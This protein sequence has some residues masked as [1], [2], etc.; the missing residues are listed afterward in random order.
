MLFLQLMLQNFSGGPCV[1]RRPSQ[2]GRGLKRLLNVHKACAL[3]SPLARGA[4][5]ETSPTR[6]R[7]NTKQSPLARGAWI[8]TALSTADILA[9]RSPLARGAWIE[10]ALKVSQTVIAGV[11]PRKR[12]VD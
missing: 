12:G 8:E 4:W 2:E 5:I 3:P 1:C 11:A 9:A 6:Y 10:T 7:R